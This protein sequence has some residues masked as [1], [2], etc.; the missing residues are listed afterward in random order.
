MLKEI[1]LVRHGE[2]ELNAA[3]MV[4]GQGID[5]GLNEVGW[6]QGAHFFNK[7][8][9]IPFDLVV[10]TNLIRTRQTIQPFLTSPLPGMQFDDLTEISWGYLEGHVNEG[11]ILDAYHAINK[12]WDSG[13]LDEKV[14]GGE[15]VNELAARCRHF[16][17]WT[18]ALR[19]DRLLVCTHGR[20]IR[21]LVCLI[22]GW[23]L[24]RMH[25]AD[26]QN[27]GLYIFRKDNEKWQMTLRNDVSHLEQ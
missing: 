23:D 11:A 7:Y 5:A 6:Q 27:T 21:A 1:Y 18:A 2:T 3:N 26:H 8:K 9:E 13:H 20:T 17:D 24:T 19:M 4:Q 16:L 14:R 10:Y 22:L 25:E 12:L 15:S